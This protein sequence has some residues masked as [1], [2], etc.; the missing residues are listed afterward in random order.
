METPNFKSFMQSTDAKMDK[1][2]AD[3]QQS[4]QPA[5]VQEGPSEE[6]KQQMMESIRNRQMM[7]NPFSAPQYNSIRVPDTPI[8]GGGGMAE[9]L[10]NDYEVPAEIKQKHWWVFHKDNTL[11]FLDEERKRSKLLNFDIAKIDILNTLPY[12]DYTF[13]M[14]LELGVLRNVFETKLDRAMGFRGTN[15]KNERIVLQSS[16]SEN[17]MINESGGTPSTV[18]AGFFQRLLGRK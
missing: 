16:F 14:E 17:R 4:N 15:Q 18:R 9:A 11:T 8:V 2:V 12:Y 13:E 1:F 3:N 7:E 6:Q 10:L 5:P